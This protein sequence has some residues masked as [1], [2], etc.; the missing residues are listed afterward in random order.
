MSITYLP[1]TADIEM[2]VQ[3]GSL[4]VLFGAAIRG[5]GNILKEGGCYAGVPCPLTRRLDLR[6]KDATC[7]LIDTLSDIL[8]LSFIDKALFCRASFLELTETHMVADLFGY[9]VNGFDEEI[10]AVTYH[11]AQLR[12]TRDKQ[13]KTRVIFDI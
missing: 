9:A 10:K 12:R 11:G 2:Q 4:D 13:W 1:H 3:A 8:S 6:A 7:L 5:M